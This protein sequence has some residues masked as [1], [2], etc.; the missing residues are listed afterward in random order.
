MQSIFGRITI[1]SGYRAPEVNR[2]CNEKHLGCA[3]NKSDQSGHIWDQ[4]LKISY[5]Q[6]QHYLN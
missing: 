1:S 5:S 6:R 4:Y 3:S 2:I